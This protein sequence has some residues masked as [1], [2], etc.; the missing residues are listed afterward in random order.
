MALQR[1]CSNNCS[2]FTCARPHPFTVSR[3]VGLQVLHFGVCLFHPHT[4]TTA[5]SS[6]P[7]TGLDAATGSCD[8]R[9]SARALARGLGPVLIDMSL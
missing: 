2:C 9:Q 1:P 8:T 3:G 5:G 6:P 4:A 7:A